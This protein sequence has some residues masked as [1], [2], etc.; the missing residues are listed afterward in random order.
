V[1]GSIAGTGGAVLLAAIALACAF[2]QLLTIYDPDA[3]DFSA[4]FAAPGPAHPMGTD[5]MGRDVLARVLHG[6]RVTLGAAAISSAASLLLAVMWAAVSA[7]LGGMADEIMTRVADMVMNIPNLLL[8]LLLV[9]LIGPGMVGLVIALGAARWA[10]Y[11]RILRGQVLALLGEEYV[12]ASRASGARP[13]HIIRHHII[14]NLRPLALKLLG[15]NFAACVLS[16]SGLSFLGF[17]VRPPQ[18]EWGAMIDAAR[19]F[20]QSRPYLMAFP[21]AAVL[22]SILA[23]NFTLELADRS[24]E[25]GLV[26][27]L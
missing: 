19:P 20:M 9:S 22:L 15:L 27:R 6:G 12:L 18:A 26:S 10:G 23:A 1:R 5:D 21:S 4:K 17:G 8:V 13:V 11:A 25:Q 14:P 16:I 2:P 3:I 7:S 24:A